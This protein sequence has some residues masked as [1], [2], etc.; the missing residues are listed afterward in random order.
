MFTSWKLKRTYKGKLLKTKVHGG[1]V[2]DRQSKIPGFCQETLSN[3]S[4]LCAGAGGLGTAI[5]EPLVRKGIGH[6][7]LCD[8]DNVHPSNL[9]RQ[10]FYEHDIYKNK[11]LCLA[12][13]LSKESFLGTKITGIALNFRDAIDSGLVPEFDCIISATDDELAREEITEFALAKGIP[14]I[15]TGVSGNGD[16]GYVHVQKPGEA[17]WGCAFPREHRLHDDLENYRAPCPG[18]PAIKDILMIVGGV[19]V[20]ALDCVFMDRPISWNYREFHLAG[21]MPDVVKQIERLPECHL[22]GSQANSNTQRKMV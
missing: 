4:A 6:L 15:T 22:C 12:M 21:F 3:R 7:T 18:T 13:N 1:G 10:K 11:G 16:S 5:G 9:N 20:Y 8:E 2:A 14:L 19:A 17:C